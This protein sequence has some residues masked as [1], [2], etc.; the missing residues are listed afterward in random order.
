MTPFRMRGFV[1]ILLGVAFLLAVAT[2]LVL[3]LSHSP[4]TFGIGKGAW[5]HTHIVMSLVMLIAGV[6]HL[7][8]NWSVFR[9]YFVERGA[10]RLS[11]KRELALALAIV[12]ILAVPGFFGRHG[13]M[14]QMGAT[15][16]VRI[17]EQCGKPVDQ[18]VD[19]LKTEGIEVHNPGD[20]LV[21][22]SQHNG[23]SP[24]RVMDILRRNLPEMMRRKHGA[25]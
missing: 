23:Q 10:F 14:Q 24:M 8:L 20:T 4:E 7:C 15:S 22:I 5:R 6:V 2:G 1:S 18:L 3:W 21:E 17:A 9:S 11:H 12:A 16:L 25:H 19:L 13:D